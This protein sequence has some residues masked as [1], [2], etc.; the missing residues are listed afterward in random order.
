MKASELIDSLT[1]LVEEHGDLELVDN[2]NGNLNI[3]FEYDKNED[4]DPIEVF[5]WNLH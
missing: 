5:M 3:V 2:D 4:F 1:K